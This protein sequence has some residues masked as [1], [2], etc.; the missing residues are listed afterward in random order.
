MT[1]EAPTGQVSPNSVHQTLYAMMAVRAIWAKF[2]FTGKPEDKP[3]GFIEEGDIEV[4]KEE[5]SNVILSKSTRGGKA[6]V[7]DEGSNVS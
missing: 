5:V 4:K 3:F 2:Q 6:R 1:F 7:C